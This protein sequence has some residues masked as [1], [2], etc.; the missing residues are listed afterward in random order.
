ME[1]DMKTNKEVMENAGINSGNFFYDQ[2]IDNINEH[3]NK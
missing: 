3:C 1:Y 2:T